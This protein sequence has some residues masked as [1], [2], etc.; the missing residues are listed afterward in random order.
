MSRR[1][2]YLLLALAALFWAAN[3]ALGRFL[4]DS[5]PPV[6]LSFW[7]WTGAL[8]VMTPLALPAL[9]AHRATLREDWK[10]VLVLGFLSV[11][12]FTTL[13]YVGLRYTT[14]TNLSLLNATM[15]VM[16]LI[17]ARLLLGHVIGRQ[18]LAGVA[19]CLAGVVLIVGQ[20]SLETLLAV[21]VNPGDPIILA[22]M[23]CWAAYSVLLARMKPRLPML[24]FQL[25][26]FAAG[27]V[28]LAAGFAWEVAAGTAWW[29]TLAVGWVPLVSLV[30]LA[31]FPSV[32]AF[33][34]WQKG[35]EATSPGTAGYFI[36]LVPVFGT[37]LAVVTLGERLYWYHF[38]GMAAIFAGIWL[39]QRA[40]RPAISRTG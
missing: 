21:Q 2:A 7:R 11:S 30:F 4:V 22:A 15:P 34:F 23:L 32:L 5:V 19:V 33:L 10:A 17:V 20:G 25:A 27:W 16:I 38:A 18:R 24:P 40:P 12:G 14:A 31:V 36:Y 28:F 29:P 39:A 9:W 1:Q 6:S 35:I 8:I 26:A 3:P 13:V 37:L